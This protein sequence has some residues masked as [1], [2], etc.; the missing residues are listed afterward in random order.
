MAW[1]HGVLPAAGVAG[2]TPGQLDGQ[3]ESLRKYGESIQ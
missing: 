2:S 3:N 1:T